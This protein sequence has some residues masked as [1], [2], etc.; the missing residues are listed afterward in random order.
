MPFTA[1]VQNTFHMSYAPIKFGVGNVGRIIQ[2][3]SSLSIQTESSQD[4]FTD[5]VID[6]LMYRTRMTKL[7]TFVVITEGS[8]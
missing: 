5:E 4:L 2:T 8:T 7:N 3:E 1:R 6:T